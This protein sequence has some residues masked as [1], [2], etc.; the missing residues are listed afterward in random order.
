MGEAVIG[1]QLFLT[2]VAV[3]EASAL[4]FEV[5]A[6]AVAV[7]ILLAWFFVAFLSCPG[8]F[9]LAN[10]LA[11][12]LIELALAVSTAVEFTF[13]FGAVLASPAVSA[14][15]AMC[16]GGVSTFPCIDIALPVTRALIE[17]NFGV[18]F[19]TSP[20]LLTK[21]FEILAATMAMAVVFA[22]N[23]RAVET[24]V[25]TG[26]LTHMCTSLFI[27][28]ALA[29]VLTRSFAKHLRTVFASPAFFAEAASEMA[30]VVR[31][32]VFGAIAAAMMRTRIWTNL[33]LAILTFPTR[34]ADTLLVETFSMSVAILRTDFV[35]TAR[36][37]ETRVTVALGNS[38]RITSTFSTTVAVRRV[39]QGFGTEFACPTRIASTEALN[40]FSMMAVLTFSFFVATVPRP[41]CFAMAAFTF[42]AIKSERGV[43]PVADTMRITVVGALLRLAF[44]SHPI[45]V[46]VTLLV[47]TFSV[48]GATI[49]TGFTF[50]RVSRKSGSAYTL[51]L[52]ALSCR[53]SFASAMAL[54]ARG[55]AMNNLAGLTTV[56]WHAMTPLR[57]VFIIGEGEFRVIAAT[58]SIAVFWADLNFAVFAFPTRFAPTF[59]VD[60]F[61]VVMASLGAQ[62]VDTG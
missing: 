53:K 25:G 32:G 27:F 44:V 26:A 56:A 62:H 42:R 46:T 6:F 59:V 30:I 3:P 57:K 34:L 2:V 35:E 20:T 43:F 15:A 29:T 61:A 9:T 37:G 24:S 55:V 45:F 16:L 23:G 13:R 51:A 28:D 1:A 52:D 39:A 10:T 60:A 49:G 54:H 58:A 41:A 17:A 33:D 8:T 38:H 7:T 19:C 14:E 31:V 47:K 21:T 4:A 5:N 40:A 50:A 18:T 11:E 48:S 12:L 22:P 36:A